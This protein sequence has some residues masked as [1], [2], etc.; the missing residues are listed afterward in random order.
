MTMQEHVLHVRM[1]HIYVPYYPYYYIC[2]RGD[3]SMFLCVLIWTTDLGGGAGL[4]FPP[5]NSYVGLG[6]SAAA[7]EMS[8]SPK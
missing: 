4:E 7:F 1:V 8:A 2:V 5:K 3:T 6:D